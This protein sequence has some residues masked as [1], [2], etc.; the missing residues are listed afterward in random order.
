MEKGIL[1]QFYELKRTKKLIDLENCYLMSSSSPYAVHCVT[2]L[3]DRASLHA[4]MYEIW[5]IK[6]AI[7][8][9]LSFTYVKLNLCL[10]SRPDAFATKHPRNLAYEQERQTRTKD[11]ET[12]PHE[13]IENEWLGNNL[14]FDDRIYH[15]V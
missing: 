2:S 8:A 12:I 11:E 15:H 10:T 3:R 14:Y 5:G 13:A 6:P 1:L 9:R 7:F 4:E